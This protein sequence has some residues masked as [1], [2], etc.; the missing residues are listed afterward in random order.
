MEI[1]RPVGGGTHGLAAGSRVN[2][3]PSRNVRFGWGGLVAGRCVGTVGRFIARASDLPDVLG[4]IKRSV[5]PRNLGV[6]SSPGRCFVI[7]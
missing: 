4:D 2:V 5:D 6:C 1:H 3:S 7:H